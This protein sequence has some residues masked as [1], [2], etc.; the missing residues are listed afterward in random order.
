MKEMQKR[1]PNRLHEYDYN[2]N[3]LYFITMCTKDRTELF[4]NVVVDEPV[5][6][7]P[8]MELTELG[9]YIYSAIKYYNE[10]NIIEIEKNVV[11]PNHI[12]MIINLLATGD[13]G[14]SPLQYVVRNFK[15]YVTKNAGYSPW[16]RSF[17][18]HIIRNQE[19]YNRIA[20]YIKNNPA[21]WADDRYHFV[22]DAALGVPHKE[23]QHVKLQPHRSDR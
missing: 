23:N 2:Q 9:K 10:N 13:R 5:P 1:K 8:H 7:R 15:S 18:D 17:H 22:G 21:R 16:Q 3:G 19:D 11:M 6:G 14:R 12:H 20:E 4:G